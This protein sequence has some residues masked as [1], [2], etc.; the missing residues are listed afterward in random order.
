MNEFQH[1]VPKQERIL[2]IVEAPCHFVKVGRKMLR[3]D[4]MPPFAGDEKTG[5][6]LHC[7]VVAPSRKARE[8]AHPFRL[9]VNTSQ[10]ELYLAAAERGYP[11][12]P[13]A[14]R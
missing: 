1:R 2:A 12:P 4:P 6:M 5:T 13:F 9:G 14:S 10:P 3:R 7:S 11:P 8:G